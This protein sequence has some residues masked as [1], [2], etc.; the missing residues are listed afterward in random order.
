MT[1]LNMTYSSELTNLADDTTP[2]EYGKNY[3]DLINKL[4]HAIEKLFDWFQCNSFKT[5]SSNV[6]FSSHH[7]NQLR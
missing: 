2:Y 4:E 3:G 6:I 7:I 5:N 1:Y